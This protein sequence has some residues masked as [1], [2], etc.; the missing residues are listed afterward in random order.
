MVPLVNQAKTDCLSHPMKS[1]NAACV[2]DIQAIVP[3][4]IK[5]GEDVVAKNWVSL[6]ADGQALISDVSKIKTDCFASK[7]V[8]KAVDAECINDIVAVL[9]DV[10]AVVSDVESFN[11]PGAIAAAQ[12]VVPDAEKAIDHCGASSQNMKFSAACVTDV[13]SIIAD[14]GA[15]V[16]DIKSA[17]WP[18]V[19]VD[20]SDMVKKGISFKNDCLA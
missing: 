20:A 6:I 2:A 3:V 17:A 5:V 12:K 10:E 1:I 7:N 18:K 4:V 8:L 14:I 11:I 15:I 9:V 16:I 19:F 13:T